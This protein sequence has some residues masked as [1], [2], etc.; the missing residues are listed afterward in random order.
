MLI[1]S[2]VGR[3]RLEA[4]LDMRLEFVAHLFLLR[5]EIAGVLGLWHRFNRHLFDDFEFVAFETDDFARVVGHEQNF[6]HAQYA[7]GFCYE[8][9]KGVAKRQKQA[10]EWY[11]KAAVQGHPEA[12]QKI[13]EIDGRRGPG[14]RPQYVPR[15]A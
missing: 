1:G 15:F 3:G 12:L 6:A 13:A 9:G 4:A 11:R 7:L 8:Q 10:E 14:R 2:W 5:F